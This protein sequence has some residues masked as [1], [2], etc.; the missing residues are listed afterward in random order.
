MLFDITV[1]DPLEVLASTRRVLESAQFVEINERRLK[2]ISK[3]VAN[4][5]KKGLED[6]S[7]SFGTRANGVHNAQ[8]IFIEDAVNFCFW[9]EK[10]K[11][12]WQIE[13]PEGNIVTGGWYALVKSFERSLAGSIRILDANYLS[14]IKLSDVQDLF[15]SSNGVEIP[16]IAERVK[17]LQEVGKVLSQKYDGQF[18]NLVES[19]KFDAIPLVKKIY[20]E[21]SSFGD[22]A[23]FEG[24]SVYLLKRAQIVASD[25]TYIFP[26]KIKN[27]DLLRGFADY[28]L[29]QIFRE[30]GL[31]AYTPSLAQDI[32][33]YKL[34]TAGSRE[35]VEIRSA[36][37]WSIELIR[38]QLEKYTSSQI[39]NAVWLISQDQSRVTH[40]YHRTYTIYY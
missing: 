34:I 23:S 30:V 32:D 2:H 14:E 18:I 11:E 25:L 27:A 29:P 21:F 35:E 22:I 16:L 8:L 19:A 36:T 12:K 6:A 5:I 7:T 37:V 20:E 40:P 4:K 17:N 1:A 31:M 10:G 39:D 15:R 9:A 24:Q 33:D 38:Q 26:E 28:K 3:L 13:W